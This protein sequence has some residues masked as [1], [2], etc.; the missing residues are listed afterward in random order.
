MCRIRGQRVQR[1]TS[2]AASSLVD[3]NMPIRRGVSYEEVQRNTM[4]ISCLFQHVTCIFFF[5]FPFFFSRHDIGVSCFQPLLGLLSQNFES[6]KVSEGKYCCNHLAC[7]RGWYH[8]LSEI[9]KLLCDLASSL[10]TSHKLTLVFT[11]PPPPPIPA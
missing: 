3:D 8:Y 6:K 1:F 2:D 7:D 11:L 9:E 10:S 4:A 5:S